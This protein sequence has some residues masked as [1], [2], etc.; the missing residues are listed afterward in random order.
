M[1]DKSN[2][3]QRNHCLLVEQSWDHIL[4]FCHP[5]MVSDLLGVVDLGEGK[6]RESWQPEDGIARDADDSECLNPLL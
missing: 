4:V 2:P 3:E 1:K 6:E 5:L